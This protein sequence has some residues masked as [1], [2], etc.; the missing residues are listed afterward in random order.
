MQLRA[1][2]DILS[3][4]PEGIESNLLGFL[5]ALSQHIGHIAQH[6]LAATE[7]CAEELDHLRPFFPKAG[8]VG[9]N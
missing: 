8:D 3:Q 4:R 2:L 7:E 6:S 9:A 1:T 5:I